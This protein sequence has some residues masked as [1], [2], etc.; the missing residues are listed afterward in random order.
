MVETVIDIANPK[1][2][3]GMHENFFD[4]IKIINFTDNAILRIRI[5]MSFGCPG[6]D[7]NRKKQSNL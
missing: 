3:Q 4:I 2:S 6:P 7:P 5:F 1:F